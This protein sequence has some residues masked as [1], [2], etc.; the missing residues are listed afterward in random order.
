M[1]FYSFA[2]FPPPVMNKL[3]LIMNLHYPR[4]LPN[5]LQL[6]WPSL[7]FY[8][9]NVQLFSI[10]NYIFLNKNDS[11][12]V[13]IFY[14]YPGDHDLY[15]LA[16]F[17]FRFL[18]LYFYVNNQHDLNK[19]KTENAFTQILAFPLEWFFRRWHQQF[20]IFKN[21]APFKKNF[22]LHLINLNLHYIVIL[23][24]KIGP[25]VLGNKMKI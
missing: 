8:K 15:K 13:V 3:N 12:F 9:K 17:C 4:M 1:T 24:S 16:C 14:M 23:C 6:F 2:T 7:V 19:H 11:P 20:F 18:S 25:V 10:F 21:Y 22:T 5:K